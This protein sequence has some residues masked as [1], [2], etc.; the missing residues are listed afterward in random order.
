MLA[1]HGRTGIRYT[2]RYR[3]PLPA[4]SL[5]TRPRDARAFRMRVV[6]SLLKPLRRPISARVIRILRLISSM[7]LRSSRVTPSGRAASKG[8]VTAM[9]F[10]RM[11]LNRQFFIRLVDARDACPKLLDVIESE[12]Y[13]GHDGI[14]RDR[15]ATP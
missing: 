3:V 15:D 12:E 5:V 14:P 13:V 4:P 10:S 9:E 1:A 6:L 2:L 11:S 7:S 8:K